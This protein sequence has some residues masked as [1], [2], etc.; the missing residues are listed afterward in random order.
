MCRLETAHLDH[1]EE[2]FRLM[3]TLQQLLE[4]FSDV[5]APEFR[6]DV[7]PFF[8]KM[9]PE[10]DSAWC[11]CIWTQC[12]SVICPIAVSSF[13]CIVIYRANALL[14]GEFKADDSG[15]WCA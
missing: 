14:Q 5:L 8:T 11:A 1:G 10:L 7:I 6:A 3:T 9:F 2:T 4:R 13:A 12:L 15:V